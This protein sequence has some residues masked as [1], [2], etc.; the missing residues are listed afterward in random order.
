MLN[1]Q[2]KYFLY[3]ATVVVPVCKQY[4]SNA[5]HNSVYKHRALS[6]IFPS[7]TT[8]RS[9]PTPLPSPSIDLCPTDKCLPNLGKP[10]G[11]RYISAKINSIK[12]AKYNSFPAIERNNLFC[13]AE[14]VFWTMVTLLIRICQALG[15]AQIYYTDST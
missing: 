11:R 8:G 5:L 12:G 14:K 6:S 7:L 3:L 9:P 13:G 15:V 10:S 2:N 1:I 4:N